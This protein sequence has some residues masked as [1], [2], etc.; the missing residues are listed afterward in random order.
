MNKWRIKSAI[1]YSSSLCYC[2]LFISKEDE[3]IEK[4]G[5]MRTPHFTIFDELMGT[6]KAALRGLSM[7]PKFVQVKVWLCHLL[8]IQ[9][10]YTSD[11]APIYISS[12]NPTFIIHQFFICFLFSV[13]QVHST[14]NL[15]VSKM[16]IATPQNI[17]R[18]HNYQIL[19]AMKF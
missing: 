10:P 14:T 3:N 8:L 12:P 15:F 1:V 13:D 6:I 17:R 2:I 4:D 9:L 18:T 19:I 11:L 5:C 16:Q 7:T